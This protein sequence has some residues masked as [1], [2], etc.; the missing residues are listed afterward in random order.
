MRKIISIMLAC[1][2]VVVMCCVGVSTVSA[3]SSEATIHVYDFIGEAYDRYADT[4]TQLDGKAVS[5]DSYQFEVGDLV[6]V[7]ISIQSDECEAIS[8]YTAHTF[9]NQNSIDA[10]TTDSFKDYTNDINNTVEISDLYFASE[11]GGNYKP[12]VFIVNDLTNTLMQ[13]LPQ[14][15]VADESSP[16]YDPD[17]DIERDKISYTGMNATSSGIKISSEK[18]IVTFT[19]QIKEATE[20][21][22]YT[23]FEDVVDTSTDINTVTNDINVKTTLEKVGHIDIEKPTEAPTLAPTEAPTPAP[24][25]APTKAPTEA[26]TPAPTEAPTLAPT[27][28]PTEVTSHT[29]TVVGSENLCATAWDPA[30]KSNDMTDMGNN[31][32]QKVFTNVSAGDIEFKI[33]QNYSWD[34]S[35]GEPDLP[36]YDNNYKDTVLYDNATVTINFNAETGI[37]TW[38]IDYSETPTDAPTETPTVDQPTDASTEAPTVD[39]PTDASTEVSTID[40]QSTSTPTGTSAST[41]ATQNS[42]TQS[43]QSSTTSQT[44]NSNT[45]NSNSQSAS[46]TTTG[47]VATGDSTS[48]TLL[49]IALLISSGAIISARKKF[50]AK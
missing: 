39:Q 46:S 23:A 26:P 8:G 4:Q 45:S 40:D 5:R 12:G 13:S 36:S 30:E 21:Y 9:I 15:A 29:Y 19:V 1:M 28:V 17:S 22:L 27:E 47:K 38:T 35:F 34:V 32:Y 6:N 43:T 16:Y 33:V 44:S 10:N 42:T 7:V 11:S 41:N 25:E 18:K 20:C 3:D 24:T 37:A 50:I 48:V 49:L 14:V 31:V 2:L